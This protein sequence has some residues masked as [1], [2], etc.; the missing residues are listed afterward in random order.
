MEINFANGE[1]LA[2][3]TMI[4]N[5]GLLFAMIAWERF[6][7]Y[8]T[9]NLVWIIGN[10]EEILTAVQVCSVCGKVLHRLSAAPR[11]TIIIVWQD[12]FLKHV[13]LL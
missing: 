4:F 5:V 11:L 10:S 1:N 3:T 8:T 6:L 13:C 7:R 9:I 2:N 12:F